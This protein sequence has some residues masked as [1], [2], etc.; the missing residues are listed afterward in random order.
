MRPLTSLMALLF[1]DFNAAS[2]LSSG[3]GGLSYLE[4]L[5]LAPER[6]EVETV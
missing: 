6:L 4:A 1:Q 5:V 2:T 3:N